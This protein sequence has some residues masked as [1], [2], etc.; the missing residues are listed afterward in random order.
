MQP[1]NIDIGIDIAKSSQQI[2][3]LELILRSGASKYWYCYCYCKLEQAEI[4]IDIEPLVLL[5]HIPARVHVL[6]RDHLPR[7]CF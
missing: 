2:L 3:V 6:F 7:P 5:S 1:A 4:D